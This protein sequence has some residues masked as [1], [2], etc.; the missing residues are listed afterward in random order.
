MCHR[1]FMVLMHARLVSEDSPATLPE[2]PQPSLRAVRGPRPS[3]PPTPLERA[4]LDYVER[5][6]G[7]SR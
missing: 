7:A 6:S 4:I 5:R 2:R 3:L 1:P